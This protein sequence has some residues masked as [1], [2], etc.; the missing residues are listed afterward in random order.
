MEG[1]GWKQGQGQGLQGQHRLGLGGRDGRLVG[2][3]WVNG[4]AAHTALKKTDQQA[5]KICHSTQQHQE[6]HAAGRR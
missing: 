2:G 4:H 6:Q 5:L 1:A 3:V